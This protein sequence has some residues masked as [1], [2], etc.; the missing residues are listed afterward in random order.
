MQPEACCWVI[1]SCYTLAQS[2]LLS[3]QTDCTPLE[4]FKVVTPLANGAVAEQGDEWCGRGCASH[5]GQSPA[6]AGWRLAT[7]VVSRY[8]GSFMA[9]IKLRLRNCTSW[10]ILAG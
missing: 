9:R 7:I 3:E 1:L 10:H 8:L 6:S 2:W 5:L 4:G